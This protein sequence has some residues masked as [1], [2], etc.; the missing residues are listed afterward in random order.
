MILPTKIN[1]YCTRTGDAKKKNDAGRHT[2]LHGT[3][4]MKAATLLT[5]ISK[6]HQF[7]RDRAILNFFCLSVRL[8]ES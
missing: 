6:I 2:S 1:E 3:T 4:L 5:S 7:M 8:P